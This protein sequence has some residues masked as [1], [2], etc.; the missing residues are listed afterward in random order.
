MNNVYIIMDTGVFQARFWPHEFLILV[1]G[2]IFLLSWS[3]KYL[4]RT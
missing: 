2:I 3:K 1:V 4:H